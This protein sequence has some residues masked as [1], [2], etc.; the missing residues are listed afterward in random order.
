MVQV[1][2]QLYPVQEACLKISYHHDIYIRAFIYII[3]G[4]GAKQYYGLRTKLADYFLAILFYLLSNLST[5]LKIDVACF[6]H[7]L[8]ISRV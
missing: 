4:K 1:K 6:I 7:L 5:L 2:E 8:A 3:R